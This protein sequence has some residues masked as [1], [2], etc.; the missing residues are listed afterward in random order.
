MDCLICSGSAFR[1]SVGEHV[2]VPLLDSVNH[3]VLFDIVNH[4]QSIKVLRYYL[5]TYAC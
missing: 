5:V 2:A 3:I 1:I 4:F